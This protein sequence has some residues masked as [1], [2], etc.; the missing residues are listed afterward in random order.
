MSVYKPGI[1]SGCSNGRGIK[2]V[3][4]GSP[5]T[6]IHTAVSGTDENVVDEVYIYAYNGHTD[7]VTLT[8]Q[9]GGT[10]S[11]DDDCV[12]NLASKSGEQMLIPG[13]RFN[14]SV[15]IKAYASVANVIVIR[16]IVNHITNS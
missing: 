6:T 5:G 14:N 7:V 8:L 4:T 13:Y 3:Q 15:V 10:T 12:V 16:C 1:A 11:P 2:V 9:L